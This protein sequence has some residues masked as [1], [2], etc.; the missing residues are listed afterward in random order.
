MAP[1]LSRGQAATRN[2][3][4]PDD[5]NPIGP[6][7]GISSIPTLY[8]SEQLL[9]QKLRNIGYDEAREDTYRLRG[10]QLIDNVRETLQLPVKTFDTAATY[11]HKFRIRFPSAEYNYEDAAL[12]SLFVACKVEDTIKK[13]KEILCAAHNLRQPLDHKSPD[14]K[15]FESTSKVM[16]GLERYI[17]ETIGFDFRVQYP[18][19][20]LVKMVRRMFSQRKDKERAE[21]D[22]K[23]FLRDAYDM[24]IDLYKT[25]APIKQTTFAMVSA[26]IELTAIL[27]DTSR[28]TVQSFLG[29]LEW[30]ITR[31]SVFETMLDLLDL[32]TRAP[33]TTK[34]GS[35]YELNRLM[36]VK[37]TI[38]NSLAE[39]KLPR[40]HG[41]CD[42][43]LQETPDIVPVTPGSATSP[44]T[45]NSFSGGSGNSVKRN[46]SSEGTMRFV[47]DAA[48]ARKERDRAAEFFNDEYE[49]Y[50]VEV[51]EAIREPHESSRHSSGGRP[52]R[53]H[54][55]NN[56]NNNHHNDH[57]WTPYQRSGRHGHH[58][59]R[60]KGR[61]GHGYY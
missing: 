25:F 16:I 36:D 17:L 34:V 27:T 49:E 59:D 10:V 33:K 35:R 3:P 51:E 20:L 26:I 40:Y 6:P 30:H 48:E 22:G 11:Y 43:C 32:Y 8:L 47:F 1:Q 56:N 2:A 28:E 31:G 15:V 37:I 58:G 52:R 41:S 42:R 46:P 14:D 9:R 60:H 4:A 5:S 44:A 54:H 38:N 50:E 61:K 21:S 13:S 7:S 18:Q 12:A 24:S 45:N 55:N 39:D 53:S 29:S 57:G 19:K 23:R